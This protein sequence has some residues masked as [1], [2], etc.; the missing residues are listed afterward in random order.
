MPNLA[1]LN[2]AKLIMRRRIPYE[3]QTKVSVRV[4]Y[5]YPQR[6]F[7]AVSQSVMP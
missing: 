7:Y 3:Q 5:E 2:L 4:P 1:G 6:I